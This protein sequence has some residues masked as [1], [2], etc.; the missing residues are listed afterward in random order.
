MMATRPKKYFLIILCIVFLIVLIFFLRSFIMDSPESEH[1]SL[2]KFIH[3]VETN[4]IDSVTIIGDQ[5][6]EA[7]YNNKLVFTDL[8]NNLLLLLETEDINIETKEEPTPPW[9]VTF[10]GYLL[11]FL[12]LII[13][14]ALC[15]AVFYL[16]F[17]KKFKMLEEIQKDIKEIKDKLK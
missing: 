12:I 11:P 14:F 13:V 7:F 6:V 1:V 8:N 15:A 10:L 5:K 3:L 17:R 4:E 9:F 16:V 2:Y